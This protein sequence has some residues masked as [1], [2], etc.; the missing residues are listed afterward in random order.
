MPLITPEEARAYR[1]RWT[2]VAAFEREE[3]RLTPMETKLSQLAALMA[4]RHVFADDPQRAQ[5][6][7]DVRERWAKLRLSLN[8]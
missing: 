6:V 4:S 8:D 5:G 1:E 2:A 7:L 3:L